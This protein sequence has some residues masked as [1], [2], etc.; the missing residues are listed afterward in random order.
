[1]L[2]RSPLADKAR[3]A[4]QRFEAIASAQGVPHDARLIMDEADDGLAML[5]RFADLLV[6]SQDDPAESLSDHVLR[7]PDYVIMNSARPVL[8]I[9]R[10]DE[11]PDAGFAHA[12]AR[13][14]TTYAA[15]AAARVTRESCRISGTA[16][17]YDTPTASRPWCTSRAAT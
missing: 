15:A 10:G 11:V 16:D 8:V 12:K 9:P 4:L 5:S 17:L 3:Q 6:V 1:M 14:I 7:L 13:R 2:F